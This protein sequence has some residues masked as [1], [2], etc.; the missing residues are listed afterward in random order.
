MSDL[1]LFWFSFGSA[2][3][4]LAAGAFWG[5]SSSVKLP[6]DF[7]AT[8]AEMNKG[9]AELAHAMRKSARLNSYAAICAMFAAVL[10]AIVISRPV[11]EAVVAS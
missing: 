1:L 6:T 11:L 8:M 5:W 2:A 7:S 9:T 3:F 4:A 10:Q